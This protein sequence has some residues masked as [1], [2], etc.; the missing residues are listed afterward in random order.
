LGLGP[1]TALLAWLLFDELLTPA[2]LL[3][4]ALTA[5]GVALVTAWARAPSTP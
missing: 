1:C 2:M 5:A 4:L 3:G